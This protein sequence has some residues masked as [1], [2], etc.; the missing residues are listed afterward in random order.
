MIASTCI[1]GLALKYN[2]N[3]K[4]IAIP[5]KIPSSTPK[6]KHA[7]NV[8]KNGIKFISENYKKKKH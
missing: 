6:N 8:V 2:I 4:S 7:K 5:T 1:R 3:N